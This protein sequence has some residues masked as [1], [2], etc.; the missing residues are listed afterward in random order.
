[1]IAHDGGENEWR[2]VVRDEPRQRA[3]AFAAGPREDRGSTSL[4]QRIEHHTLD[5]IRIARRG[6]DVVTADLRSPATDKAEPGDQ[7]ARADCPTKPSF[8]IKNKPARW[9]LTNFR[10]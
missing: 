10:R 1:M 5:A 3:R 2:Q 6:E 4:R 9:D 7:A 8:G